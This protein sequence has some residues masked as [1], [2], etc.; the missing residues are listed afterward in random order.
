MS[1][2][3]FTKGYGFD[4]GD[5]SCEG[6]LLGLVMRGERQ[7]RLLGGG[8]DCCPTSAIGFFTVASLS[9]STTAAPSRR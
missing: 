7:R 1:R 4:R 9:A 3:H 6:E 8:H 2:S 5:S